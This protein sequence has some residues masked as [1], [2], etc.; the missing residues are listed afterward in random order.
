MKAIQTLIFGNIYISLCAVVMVQYTNYVFVLD[1]NINL[2]LFVFFATLTSYSF[3]WY[4][5]PDVHSISERYIWVNDNKHLL[6]ILFSVS[7]VIT[8]FLFFSFSKFILA[9]SLVSVFTFIYS[10][11]KIPLK[12]FVYLKKII[13]AKTAYLALVWTFVSVI[14]PVIINEKSWDFQNTLFCVN[15]F[16]LIYPVCLLFDYRDKDEDKKQNIK[17]IV[18][19]LN[20]K[21]LKILYYICLSVFFASA[22]VLSRY[23]IH[24]W[25][26]IILILP[27]IFL[28]FSFNYSIRTKSDYWYY[29]Y[30]D[31]LMMLSGVIVIIKNVFE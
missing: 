1:I 18:A 6:L 14:L 31:G 20:L 23:N 12:P 3:H 26:L 25:Q 13:V 27:G 10:A 21:G 2:F 15:R 24:T 8:L 5:T 16:F 11:C 19:I 4:L 28:L 29:F 30:L 22:L 9:L 17:N 7:F